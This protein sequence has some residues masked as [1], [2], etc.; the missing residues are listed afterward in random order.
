VTNAVAPFGQGNHCARNVYGTV[1]GQRV[2]IGRMDH[3]EDAKFLAD[4]ANAYYGQP[5]AIEADLRAGWHLSERRRRIAA[6]AA[7][8][9]QECLASF[10]DAAPV[11]RVLT[12]FEAV[13]AALGGETDPDR[14][15]LLGVPVFAEQLRTVIASTSG[16]LT[17][18]DGD[19]HG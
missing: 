10:G 1:N 9:H 6:L 5:T 14:L 17:P 2:D 7:S 12:A 8:H 11:D 4:A 19:R 18:K 16:G 3:A 15:G 13:L